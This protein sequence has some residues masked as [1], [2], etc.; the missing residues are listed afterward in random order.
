MLGLGRAIM[1]DNQSNTPKTS[2]NSDEISFDEDIKIDKSKTV[3]EA[4]S[5]TK[6]KQPDQDTKDMLSAESEIEDDVLGDNTDNLSD[7]SVKTKPPKEPKNWKKFFKVLLILLLLAGAGAAAYYYFIKSKDSSNQQQ[8]TTTDE[9]QQV[10]ENS[11]TPDTVAY[12]Y[13]EKESDPYTVFWRPADGGD[14]TQVTKLEKNDYIT[15]F[16]ALLN[17]VAYSTTKGVFSST[18]GGRTYTQIADLESSGSEALGDQ[19]TSLSISRDGKKIAYALLPGKGQ[20]KPK[21]TVFSIDP[22]GQNKTEMFSVEK[23]GVFIEAWNNEKNKMVYWSGCYN[24]DGNLV[25]LQVRNLATNKDRQISSSL[26]NNIYDGNTIDVSNDI[27][28]LV[29]AEGTPSNDSLGVGLTLEAP[30]AINKYDLSSLDKTDVATVGQA[31]EKNPNGT[32]KYREVLVGFTN[33]KDSSTVFYTDDEDLYTYDDIK[34][35]LVFSAN[36]NILLAPFVGINTFITGSGDDTTDYLLT[37]YN[38]DDKKSKQIFAG[39]NNT[40]LFGVTTK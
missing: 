34:P 39:D 3:E 24:C 23:A 38:S 25:D 28:T 29:V 31:G 4:I 33:V 10:V 15:Q 32:P 40:V 2:D 27:S 16:D 19:I 30:F 5:E 9:P 12:A 1:A 7:E 37:N 35:V 13:H 14:R 17:I 21:N 36:K 22:D 26:K 6:E 11:Y 18:D 20:E 8:T